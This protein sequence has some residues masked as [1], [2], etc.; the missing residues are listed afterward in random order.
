M[1]RPDWPFG[2]RVSRCLGWWVACAA[3][4]TLASAPNAP[5]FAAQPEVEPVQELKQA[6]PAAGLLP[7]T[8]VVYAEFSSAATLLDSPLVK[9]LWE[10]EPL[11]EIW[12]SPQVLQAR[13]GVMAVELA[14]GLK[15]EKVLRDLTHH[16]VV[17]GIDARTRGAVLIAQARDSETLQRHVR[18]LLGAARDDARSKGKADTI[19]EKE[20]RGARAYRLDKATAAV[21][22]ERLILSNQDDLIRAVIDRALDGSAA[23][24]SLLDNAQFVS[25]HDVDREQAALTS[26]ETQRWMWTWSDLAA[27]RAAPDLDKLFQRPQS[28]FGAELFFGGILKLIREAPS[29]TFSV[30]AHPHQLEFMTGWPAAA[31]QNDEEYAFFFGPDGSGEAEPML[32]LPDSLLSLTAYRDLGQLWLRAGDLF[33]Q[34]TNDQLAQADAGLTTLFSGRDFGEEILG[35]I[36]PRMQLVVI[37]QHWNPADALKPSIELPAFA[38]VMRLRDPAGMQPQLKRIFQSLIGFLNVAGAINQQPQLDMDTLKT[39]E[40][41]IVVAGTYAPETDRPAGREVPVHYNF[42]PTLLMQSDL[43]ILASTQAAGE[44]VL[45]AALAAA[46]AA[47]LA[48]VSNTDVSNTDVSNTDVS[49]TDVSNTDVSNTD[50]SNTDVSNVAQ[51]R[52]N[53][54]LTLGLRPLA[55]ALEANRELLISQNIL[56]KGHSRLEAEREV[57]LVLK[58]LRLAEAFDLEFVHHPQPHVRAVLRFTAPAAQPQ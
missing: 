58:L 53:S 51:P 37:P 20:Y 16:G 24:N 25:A 29:S 33:D 6:P 38:L 27:L 5:S 3:L 48:A 49:N 8:T 44:Q 52:L 13:T 35:A 31:S 45:A 22:G 32:H 47:S 42:S 46:Q 12:R 21:V 4:C 14:L 56:E 17:V 19:E 39:P 40:G 1:R 28:D 36:E 23:G 50:V 9:H 26:Q 55:G 57:T 2:F 41:G 30:I 34:Q 11:L 7:E 10:Q 43:A 15:F 18:R 54:R